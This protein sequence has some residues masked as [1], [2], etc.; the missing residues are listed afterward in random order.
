MKLPLVVRKR[1]GDYLPYARVAI[2]GFPLGFYALIDTGSPWTVITPM[3]VTMLKIRA[4]HN[5]PMPKKYSIVKF[6][7]HEFERRLI[8]EIKICMKDEKGEIITFDKPTTNLLSSK[9][10]IDPKEFKEVPIVIG[11]DFLRVNKFSLY[12]NPGKKTAFLEK[13]NK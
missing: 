12:F 7:G 2:K 3:G 6:A 4:F 1:F 10:Q 11:C 13:I 8:K 5:F 9:R